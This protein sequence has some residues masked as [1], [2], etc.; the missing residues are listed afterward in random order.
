MKTLEEPP[1][2]LDQQIG[3]GEPVFQQ[4]QTATIPARLIPRAGECYRGG[5]DASVPS[6]AIRPSASVPRQLR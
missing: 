6:N 5:L 3:E 4:F 1:D 2:R